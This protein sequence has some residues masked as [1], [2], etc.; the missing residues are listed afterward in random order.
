MVTC[1]TASKKVD[2]QLKYLKTSSKCSLYYEA[3]NYF[4]L[5]L[6]TTI[7]H[8]CTDLCATRTFSVTITSSFHCAMFYLTFHIPDS[9]W[10]VFCVRNKP[11]Q[12]EKQN[13]RWNSVCF[14]FWNRIVIFYRTISPNVNQT[15]IPINITLLFI[16]LLRAPRFLSK[17]TKRKHVFGFN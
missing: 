10:C 4:V 8:N 7:F 16:D 14:S 11:Q 13:T 3:L 6:S 12:H 15:P 5:I 9:R 17:A 1:C 2:C